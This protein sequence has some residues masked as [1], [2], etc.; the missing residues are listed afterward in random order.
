MENAKRIMDL[1]DRSHSIYHVVENLVSL[2]PDFTRLDETQL[3]KLSAG[4]DYVLTRNGSTFAAIRMPKQAPKSLK[5]VATHND[6]PSFKLKPNPLVKKG[7]VWSLNVEP[8]GGMIM[9]PW[10]DRPLSFAGRIVFRKDG[11]VDTKLIDA[12]ADLLVIPNLCIHMNRD[13]NSGHAFNP[14]KEMLP[15]FSQAELPEGGF[16]AYVLSQAGIEGGELLAHDLFLYTRQKALRVGLNGEFLLSPRLDDLSSAYTSALA[17]AEAK[18]SETDVQIFVSFDNEE[19]GSLTRQGANSTFLRDL[20]S[21]IVA[22]YGLNKA[23]EL[24]LISRS[25]MFS[26]DN[27]HA[28]HP[29]YPE[30]SDMTTNVKMN[31]GIVI[32]YNANAKYTSDALSGAYAKT[33]AA[34]AGVPFQEYTNRS[35]MRGGSTLGNLSNS[36]V[37][38]NCVDI[39]MAQLAMHSCVEMQG[40]EDIDHAIS[41]LKTFYET[42]T[43]PLR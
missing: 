32:K 5:I 19:V 41:F 29:N 22:A 2:F 26:A 40:T 27:A 25:F 43:E 15:V 23:E 38:L 9:A 30:I 4:Q 37:S 28:N 7:N 21:I 8:Y 24:A 42:E 11:V 13:V 33:I 6:S 20:V 35:D 34:E 12:D 36:E 31:G 14:A 17:F 1:L 16:P 39:G 3:A 10:F 18:K